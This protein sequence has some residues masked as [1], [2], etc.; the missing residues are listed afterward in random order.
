MRLTLFISLVVAGLIA[1]VSP[2]FA[3]G[4]PSELSTITVG[5]APWGVAFSPDGTKAYV[6]NSGSNTLSVITMSDLSTTTV[7]GGVLTASAAAGVAVRPSD[8][9]VLITPF[10]IARIISANPSDLT[11][12]EGTF[13]SGANPLPITMRDDGTAAYVGFGSGQIQEVNTTTLATSVIRGESGEIA[14]IAYVPQGTKTGDDIAYL[15]NITSGAEVSIGG[16]FRLSNGTG[17]TYKLPGYGRALAVD[18]TGSFAYV[19]HDPATVAVGP[20]SIG[21]NFS[22]FDISTQPSTA[23]FSMNIGGAI[24]GIALSNDEERAYVTINDQDLVKVVNLVN[25]IVTHSIGVGDG[26]LKVAVSPVGNTALVTNNITN[27]V[28]LLDITEPALTPVFDT[29]VATANGYTVNVTNYDANYTWTPSVSSG[30]VSVGIPTGSTLA[31]TITGLAA[32]TSATTTMASTRTGYTNGTA[33]VEGTA[34]ATPTPAPVPTNPTSPTESPT[35]EIIASPL[36][37]TPRNLIA[38]A[39]DSSVKLSWGPASYT[40]T[41][42]VTSYMVEALP[43]GATCTTPTNSCTVEGLSNG[44]AYTFTVRARNAAG[45]GPWSAASVAV[46]P[47]VSAVANPTLVISG[48]VKQVRG[49]AEIR[50]SG[51][52]TGIE[53]GTVIRPWLR[54]QGQK[55]FTRGLARIRI[56]ET[57]NFRWERRIAKKVLIT[58]RTT[59][60]TVRSNTIAMSR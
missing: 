24:R 35:I 55:K 48:N 4:G 34:A 56:D 25:G 11:L 43:G 38:V 16:Y 47:S 51:T 27:T 23:V 60:G 44:T 32:G 40:G 37:S 46:T 29:P 8:G 57:G 45:W 19:A 52:A 59:D 50:V 15:Q 9:K 21:D 17:T 5:S 26:P 58:F 54:V 10:N 13:S 41:S 42:P 31:L 18:S 20:Y 12:S 7:S 14:D 33:T 36:P 39:Q 22:I 49:R 28:S 2:T 3:V 53:A 1:P 30:S 6:G